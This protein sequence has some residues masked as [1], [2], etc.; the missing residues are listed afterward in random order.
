M[1]SRL[2]QLVIFLCSIVNLSASGPS[3]II[4][5]VTCKLLSKMVLVQANDAIKEVK[6]MYKKYVIPLRSVQ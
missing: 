5:D 2:P 4:D 6:Q 1:F 3:Q